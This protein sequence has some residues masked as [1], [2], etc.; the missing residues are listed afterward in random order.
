[1]FNSTNIHWA[2]T[3]F[4]EGDKDHMQYRLTRVSW[5]GNVKDFDVKG[6]EHIL[7]WGIKHVNANTV[8]KIARNMFSCH[9]VLRQ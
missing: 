7:G 1:M 3:L 5:R 6:K 2:S 9:K 8:N 4:E